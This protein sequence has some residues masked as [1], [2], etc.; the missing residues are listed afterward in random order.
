[1]Q[2]KLQRKIANI[3]KKPE[4]VRLRY[5]WGGVSAGML[6]AFIIF[7]FS[8][9]ENFREVSDVRG[10][11]DTLRS[12]VEMEKPS[13]QQLFNDSKPLN[14]EEKRKEIEGGQYFNDG[15]TG[16]TTENPAMDSD[17]TAPSGLPEVY[18]PEQP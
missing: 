17:A 11:A 10:A 18:Q 7:A 2:Q 13:L 15:F 6:F 1:M 5:V 14:V 16:S 3:R 12:K 4:H 9:Q 8:V